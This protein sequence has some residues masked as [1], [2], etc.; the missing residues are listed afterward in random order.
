MTI[1]GVNAK[2][3]KESLINYEV[4]Q[5]RAKIAELEAQIELL[6]K[7]NKQLTEAYYS[8]LRKIQI[9]IQI[10]LEIAKWSVFLYICIS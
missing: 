6:K 3:E 10:N 8:V 4:P 2:G 7:D 5:L 1:Q 9:S